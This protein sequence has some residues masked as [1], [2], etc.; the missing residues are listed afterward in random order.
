[1]IEPEDLAAWEA[2]EASWVDPAQA[3]DDAIRIRG[4]ALGCGTYAQQAR[5]RLEHAMDV[6]ARARQDAE[7]ELVRCRAV[8]ALAEDAG[9][10]A[11]RVQDGTLDADARRELAMQL[12]AMI[13]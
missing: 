11:G 1:M 7:H 2:L 12:E 3:R 6:L 4:F 13:G 8:C 10:A 5:A 9:R